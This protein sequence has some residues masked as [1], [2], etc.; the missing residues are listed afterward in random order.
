MIEPLARDVRFAARGLRRSPGFTTAAIV[1]LALGIGATTAVFSVVYGVILRPLPFPNADR[2]VQVVQLLKPN[3]GRLERHRA[4][5]TTD[6]VTEWRATSRTLAE[7]GHYGPTS[8]ALTDVAAPVRLNGARISVP[9]FRALGV[10]PLK[11]RIFVDDD[12]LPGNE[13]VVILSYSTWTRRFGSSDAVLDT[14]VT[15]S[16]RRYRVIGVM[17]EGFGFP[18]MASPFMS[19]NSAGELADAPEFW[20]PNVARPRPSSPARGGMTLVPTLALLRPDVTLE[21]ATAEANTLMPA[22]VGERF[23]IELVSARVEQVRGVR[24]VLLLFQAAVLFVLFIACV[25]VVN[26]LLARAASRRHELA[27]RLALG[28]SRSQL[29]RYAVAEGVLIG[30]GG[31]ALGCLL[32]FQIVSLFRTLP[33]FVLPRMTEIR[34]DGVVLALACGVSLMAGLLVGGA[35][36]LRALRSDLEQGTV[37]SRTA[38]A[39]RRQRPSRALLVAETAAG[40]I[41]LAGAGLLLT[42]FVKLTSVERG[43]EPDDVFTFRI[44]LPARYQEAAAHHGFHDQFADAL[45]QMPGVTSVGATDWMLGQ[46]AVGFTL[47]VDGQ[48]ASHRGIWFQTITPGVFETLQIPLRGRDFDERDRAGQATVAIVNETF[49][50]RFLAGLDPIGRRIQFQH[51]PALEIVGV[52]GDTRTRELDTEV[53]PA[54]YL[55]QELTGAGLGAP[56][57]FVRLTRDT[58]ALAGI[59]AIAARSDAGAVIFDATSLE[60]LLARSVVTPK[61]YSATA[62]GFAAV[63]VTLAALGLFAVLS[64][65]IG[66]RTREFGIR[67]A[68]GATSRT[69]ITKVMREALGTVLLGVAIGTAGAMYLSR[70]LEALL[71]GVQP[72]D[73]MTL[74]VVAVMFLGIAALASYVPARRATRVDPIAALRAE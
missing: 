73:P 52:A 48:T 42:S 28:A 45:R 26:L 70:Y 21:E 59:R 25:N 47:I 72:G 19:M 11:G 62:L 37:S 12:E 5:L 51:W 13:Q 27:V 36:A 32:A 33:P 14:P 6:Q 44:S 43:F 35:T 57:Y 1:T 22:R 69:V 56:T 34:V 66:T 31:G 74:G 2:L 50:R 16:G 20:L 64:F 55:P 38:S 24:P 67:I 18:S 53:N 29:A 71:Y 58:G 9:L 17:P 46:G 15:L 65:S 61:L 60:A 49:A 39:G 68:L 63:A 3:P 41:L 30:V 23:P 7:I 4:G 54:I 8:A 10:S 40:V